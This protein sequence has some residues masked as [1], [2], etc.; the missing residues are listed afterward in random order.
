MS[1]YVYECVCVLVPHNYSTWPKAVLAKLPRHMVWSL[2]CVS[3]T[4]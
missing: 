2:F 1:V 3:R 4:N